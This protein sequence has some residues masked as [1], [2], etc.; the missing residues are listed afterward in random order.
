M[1]VPEYT[2]YANFTLEDEWMLSTYKDNSTLTSMYVWTTGYQY[3]GLNSAVW[4]VLCNNLDSFVFFNSGNTTNVNCDSS[5]SING[6]ISSPGACPTDGWNFT[7]SVRD[8]ND[9]VLNLDLYGPSL[10][11][12]GLDNLATVCYW[13][14]QDLGATTNQVLVGETFFSQFYTIFDNE[15]GVVGFGISASVDNATLA[16]S[17]PW[18][19]EDWPDVMGPVA[20][21]CA[22]VGGI[23]LVVFIVFVC[24]MMCRK[25]EEVKL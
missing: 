23:G 15:V 11:W 18:M 20:V 16:V 21:L 10:S 2:S 5:T 12:E 7:L 14:F 25:K 4:N 22:I 9:M 1:S 24:I 3:I 6:L 17:G 19:S 8:V 13:N